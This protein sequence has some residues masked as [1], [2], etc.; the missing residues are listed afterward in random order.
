MPELRHRPGSRLSV[1]FS[2]Y[3]LYFAQYTSAWRRFAERRVVGPRD[4]AEVPVEAIDADEE[5]P[6]PRC[7]AG[8][9]KD[10]E[11]VKDALGLTTVLIYSCS[12]VRGIRPIAHTRPTPEPRSDAQNLDAGARKASHATH[13]LPRS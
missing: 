13:G 12:G 11:P 10:E 6:M 3:V 9:A 5:Y 2:M 4:A 7:T 1:Q 8:R